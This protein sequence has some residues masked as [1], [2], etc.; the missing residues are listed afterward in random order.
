MPPSSSSPPSPTSRST[1]IFRSVSFYS[2][3]VGII[4][5][6]VL[7]R[8][9]GTKPSAPGPVSP[10]ARSP[11]AE[12]LS[13]SGLIEARGENVRIASQKPGVVAKVFVK[14]GDSVSAGAPLFQLNDRESRALLATKEAELDS[15]KAATL[16]RGVLL[17]DAED[18]LR[19]GQK[20]REEGV[21]TEEEINR[22]LF[23]AERAKAELVSAESQV[24]AATAQRDLAQTTLDLLTIRAPSDGLILQINVRPGEF[25]SASKTEEPLLLLNTGGDDRLQ[26]RAD[27]DEQTAI[28][29]TPGTSASGAIKGR[30][31][32]TIPLSFVRV[33]PYVVPKR[34]LTG[35]SFERVDTRVL[36]VIYE[37]D[38]PKF[39]IYVGQQVD[40]FIDRAKKDGKDPVPT[41]N[42][43]R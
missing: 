24:E 30:S 35:D 38:R 23:A 33:E 12:S 26:V 22:R 8:R 11:Y 32:W 41:G 25:A 14:V 15:L 20:L 43:L 40:V 42:P 29:F 4:L 34:S 18:Q 27:I 37:F 19:R 21:I 16:S 7:V 5:A 9:V 1:M 31:D 6:V 36:Q 10:P 3:L 39:P 13:A 17:R 2:A 28:D